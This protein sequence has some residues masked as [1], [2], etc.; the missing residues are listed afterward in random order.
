MSQ[1]AKSVPD[2]PKAQHGLGQDRLRIRA[3]GKP[4]LL[5][6][7][8]A[9]AAA[10]KSAKESSPFDDF[11]PY[12]VIKLAHE[13]TQDLISELKR[14]GVNLVR[15][16]IL[17]ALAGRDGSTI[18]EIGERAMMQQSA[19]SRAL[20]RMVKE[21]FVRRDARRDDA[22]CAAIHLTDKGRALFDTLNAVV[23]RRERLLLAGMSPREVRGAFALMRRLIRNME[24]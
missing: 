16:R 11:L 1:K 3:R 13:L 14:E 19:L 10:I 15:W 8:T 18:S 24:R 21:G 2:V 22:R 17:A 4:V 9:P 20:A 12:L 7:R 5:T 6:P 23:R